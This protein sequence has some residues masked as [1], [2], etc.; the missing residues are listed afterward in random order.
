MILYGSLK[1]KYIYILHEFFCAMNKGFVFAGFAAVLLL[2]VSFASAFSLTDFIRGI[3]GEPQNS[4]GVV[5]GSIAING[6][7]LECRNMQCVQVKGAGQN[8]CLSAGQCYNTVCTNNTCMKVP[9]NG[10][11]QCSTIGGYCGPTH[12]ECRNSTCT[13]IQGAGN[14]T[15][16][17]QGSSCGNVTHLECRSNMC[18]VVGGNGTN[19]C[20]VAGGYC[21]STGNQSKPDLVIASHTFTYTNLTG[22]ATHRNV[23]IVTRVTNIGSAIAAVSQTRLQVWAN[24][25]YTLDR[26]TQSLAPGASV[27]LRQ[28]Y[29]LPRGYWYAYS[30][31]DQNRVVAEISETNNGRTTG[32]PV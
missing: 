7:H 5:N 26:S 1:K 6:T 31:A 29:T 16:S 25:N 3:F 13:Q 19:Q 20:A 11:R 9:G 28:E 10:S 2:S 23:T 14:N 12:L 27:D 18:T 24:I 21:N 15:C 17:P 4:P 22:N 8:L 30:Y 32:F